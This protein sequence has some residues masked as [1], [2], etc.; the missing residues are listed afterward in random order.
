MFIDELFIYF[1][2]LII[3]S[4]YVKDFLGKS[5]FLQLFRY[6][7]KTGSKVHVLSIRTSCSMHWRT[8]D[9]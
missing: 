5:H 3:H 2:I 7:T 8:H 6:V 1:S 4:T 9:A